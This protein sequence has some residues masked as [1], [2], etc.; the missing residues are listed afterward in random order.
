MFWV[1]G[2]NNHPEN[3]R[4]DILATRESGKNVNLLQTDDGY[5]P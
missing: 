1:K 4:C 3:E 2:H 5:M